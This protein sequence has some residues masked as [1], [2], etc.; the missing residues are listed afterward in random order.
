MS[1][2]AVSLI[3]KVTRENLHA[4]L[5]NISVSCPATAVRLKL[6]DQLWMDWTVTH[7]ASNLL[8][9]LRWSFA[10]LSMTLFLFSI[11]LL[12]VYLW[13][14]WSAIVVRLWTSWMMALQAVTNGIVVTF[15]LGRMG[16]TAT[17]SS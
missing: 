13:M 17:R 3:S 7:T 4:T 5:M 1:V 16:M 12:V 11:T 6:T 14:V 9:R 2:T 15:L 10:T 8:L